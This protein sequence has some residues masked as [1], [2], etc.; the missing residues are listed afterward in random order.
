M[1]LVDGLRGFVSLVVVVVVVVA[2]RRYK[3]FAQVLPGLH[4][5][6]NSSTA[7]GGLFWDRSHLVRCSFS[8]SHHPLF[9]QLFVSDPSSKREHRLSLFPFI[10]TS[11]EF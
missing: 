6:E 2:E 11:D 9:R 3:L 1:S 10:N 7:P 8:L 4:W 5:W